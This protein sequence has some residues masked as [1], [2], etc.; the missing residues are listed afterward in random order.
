MDLPRPWRAQSAHSSGKSRRGDDGLRPLYGK[1]IKRQRD[2]WNHA[3]E[4]RPPRSAAQD[5]RP[6]ASH[7]KPWHAAGKPAR[8]DAPGLRPRGDHR[9]SRPPTNAAKPRVGIPRGD[10]D[11]ERQGHLGDRPAERLNERVSEYAPGV[12]RAERHLHDHARHGDHP[13][14]TCLCLHLGALWCLSFLRSECGCRLDA[15]PRRATRTRAT[16]RRRAQRP[17]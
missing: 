3:E 11:S 5:D 17:A 16:G 12:H 14:I 7:G 4:A 6:G 13:P 1:Q 2:G 15:G 9:R 10:N 8:Q